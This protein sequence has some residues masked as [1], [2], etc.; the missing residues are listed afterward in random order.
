MPGGVSSTKNA[1]TNCVA[2]GS[3]RVAGS[4]T[5]RIRDSEQN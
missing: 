2:T 1:T 3:M 5:E 4:G